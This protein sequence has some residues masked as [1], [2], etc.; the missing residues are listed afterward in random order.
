MTNPTTP[1]TIIEPPP[2]GATPPVD[3]RGIVPIALWQ[4]K[5]FWLGILPALLTLLDM[6]FRAA[7]GDAEALPV[8]SAVYYVLGQFVD[9]TPEAIHHVMRSIAPIY[10]FIVAQQRS[11]ITR[12]YSLKPVDEDKAVAV[13]AA[14]PPEAVQGAAIISGAPVPVSVSAPKT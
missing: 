11:G 6:L 8:A 3:V 12:P 5:S 13:I 14:V 10:A 9:W 1:T 4:T 7:T 2:P